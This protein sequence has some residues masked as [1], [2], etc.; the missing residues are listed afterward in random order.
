[1]AEKFY[2]SNKI[3]ILFSINYKKWFVFIK[4]KLQVKGGAY[5][6]ERTKIQ[7]L[8]LFSREISEYNKLDKLIKEIILLETN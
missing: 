5:I 4:V 3:L 2:K 6:F 8:T 7:H 1:M